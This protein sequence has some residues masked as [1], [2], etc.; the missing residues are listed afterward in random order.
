MTDLHPH[1]RATAEQAVGEGKEAGMHRV[2]VGSQSISR[3]PAAIVGIV[4]ILTVGFTYFNGWQ[5]LLGQTAVTSSSSSS[6]AS[7][8][9]TVFHATVNGLTPASAIVKPGDSITI[10]NDDTLP[11]IFS[12]TTLRDGSGVVL[13]TPPIF[14]GLSET[15]TVYPSEVAGDHEI[16]D[17]TTPASKAIVTI[18]PP[19]PSSAKGGG[20]PFGTLDG[21][22]LPTGVGTNGA[23]L[24]V[25]ASSAN[26]S[27]GFGAKSASGSTSSTQKSSAGALAVSSASAVS[28]SPPEAASFSSYAASS[29]AT[30]TVSAETGNSVSDSALASVGQTIRTG[31]DGIALNPYTIGEG[32]YHP[33]A[34]D[35][36]KT[37]AARTTDRTKDSLHAGA[38]L[39]PPS[40]PKTGPEIWIALTGSAAGLLFA[41]RRHWN[42][43]V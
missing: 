30:T 35:P 11:H 37:G 12:S 39:R 22:D 18:L 24:G 3:A 14:Q 32:N 27:K 25:S 23:A 43:M 1:W 38:N 2:A 28:S 6:A 16:V 4:V 29:S 8:S 31:A 13:N 9:S 40:E 17:S 15:F 20:S 19:S 5:S 7:V 10:V 21:V 26:S 41:T 34:M 33:S 42:T 36:Q